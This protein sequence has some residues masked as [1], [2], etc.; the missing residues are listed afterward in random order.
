MDNNR[1]NLSIAALLI[2]FVAII[3]SAILAPDPY[4]GLTE[5]EK[6][7]KKAEEQEEYYKKTLDR[8]IKNSDEFNNNSYTGAYKEILN[9]D[10]SSYWRG[11]MIDELKKDQDSN[12][13]CLFREILK[14]DEISYNKFELIKR[15]NGG[16]GNGML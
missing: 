15:L 2:G 13:Y 16:K 14:S 4:A 10:E 3:V 5:E 11:C 8:I 7:K 6:A 1:E 9:S 12:Y